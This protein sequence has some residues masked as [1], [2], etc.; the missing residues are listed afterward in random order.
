MQARGAVVEVDKTTENIVGGKEVVSSTLVNNLFVMIVSD[1]N[2]TPQ[3]CTGTFIS[4]HHILTA[5]HCVN[6]TID[7]ISLVTGVKPLGEE[8]AL[9]L[10]PVRVDR[11]ANYNESSATERNDLAIITVAES[12]GLKADEIPALPS[13]ELARFMKGS[14]QIKFLAV[15]YGKTGASSD[16]TSNRTEGI[17][18]SVNLKANH[19]SSTILKVDQTRGQGVCYGDSGGPALKIF[20]KKHYIIGIASGIYNKGASQSIDECQGGSLYMNVVP[21]ISWINSIIN[22]SNF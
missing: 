11:H 8:Q 7:D 9:V 3:V 5:A 14:D 6:N 21:Y 13:A 17:L 4:T 22:D 19:K 16:S 2:G 1:N 18:R 12:I 20:R 10:T 15:G